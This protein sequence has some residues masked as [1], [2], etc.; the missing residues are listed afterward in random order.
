M[1]AQRVEPGSTARQRRRIRRPRRADRRGMTFLEVVFATA[2]FAIV[3][4]SILG[5]FAFTVNAVNREQKMLACAEVANR[6]I[7]AYMD[8]PTDMPDPGKTIE[9]GPDE[10]PLHF[11]YD[12]QEDPL[13]LIEARGDA[14]ER[15]RDSPL[16]ADRYV[17]VSVKVWLAEKSGGTRNAED[18]TPQ[19]VLTRMYDPAYLRNPDSF[20]RMLQNPGAGQKRFFDV[21]QGRLELRRGSG[22]RATG[23]MSR[24]SQRP[25]GVSPRDAF[26]QSRTDSGRRTRR[27]ESR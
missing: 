11:R 2:L 7:L 4:S 17:Q 22:E 10:S 16:R 3:A 26:G 27:G 20:M 9:Y 14:K 8:D 1:N 21:L 25:S 12:Y 19:F 18:S 13:V 24:P 15:M 6:L 5:V 23:G